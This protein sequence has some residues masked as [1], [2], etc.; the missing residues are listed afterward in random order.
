MKWPH[1]FLGLL[2]L[3][4]CVSGKVEG[5]SLD[6]I[7]ADYVQMTLEIGE[8][9]PGYVDAYYGPAEWRD[10]AK[11][12]P[13]SLESLAAEAAA[14]TARVNAID[15][16][17]LE[18]ME[19]RR[20]TFL[21]AQ[22]RAASTRLRMLRGERL[23][24]AEEAEGLFGVSP[25]I[26]PLSTFDPVLARIDA[27]VP[28]EGP[29]WQRVDAFQERFTIPADRLKPVFDAAIAECK[30]R[31]AAHVGL[32]AG[33][34]FTLEFVTGKSWSGYN[35][36]Q[37][38]YNSLI[39]VNTDLP[40]R[41]SRAVDLGCHEGYPGHH[42]LN[43]LLEQRL[44]QQRG[45]IE[46]SVYPL[47]SPQSLIAEG[48]AN[49]G[50]DLAFPGEERLR[51]ETSVL[52]PLAGLPTDQA[53]EYLA[54]LEAME[55][56]QGARFTIARDYLEGRTNRDRAVELTQKYQ[57]V[58]KKRAEQSVDFIDEYRSYVINYGLGED[59]VE[60]YVEAAGNT[61]EARWAVMERVI[62]EPTLPSDLLR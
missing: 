34:T 52:Y 40:I 32:P 19:Q 3:A 12:A 50:I 7:A 14:L 51:Y 8:R 4:G 43:A 33:E 16:A 37:G 26:Q 28:G 36:Y 23:S 6:E 38:G 59:M 48:S 21:L 29:L 41:I 49:Y 15:P 1:A 18:T 27:L 55:A 39:Q 17:T 11:A 62:S 24:F 45:W 57:L 10:A 58:S 20:R 44:T 60:A 13:R 2:L 9:E 61:S 5:D 30:R 25:D 54:L 42:V 31:T 56:L 22:L 35:Y 46:F 53:D 47:Y